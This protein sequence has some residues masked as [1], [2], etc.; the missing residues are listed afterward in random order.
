MFKLLWQFVLPVFCSYWAK[1]LWSLASKSEDLHSYF[2][3]HKQLL[4]EGMH[5]WYIGNHL[6]E[7][8]IYFAVARLLRL[9]ENMPVSIVLLFDF[10]FIVT[11]LDLVYYMLVY[12]E[13]ILFLDFEY[14]DLKFVVITLAILVTVIYEA[15]K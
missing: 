11:W 12:S 10:L 4:T 15:R 6:S 13:W 2:P 8:F 1:K 9:I 14:G 7:I 5:Y 3:F